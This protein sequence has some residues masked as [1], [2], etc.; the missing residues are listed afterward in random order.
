MCFRY[1]EAIG[2]LHS[3]KLHFPPPPTVLVVSSVAAA[4]DKRNQ[5]PYITTIISS[6][7]RFY[8]PPSLMWGLCMKKCLPGRFVV[9]TAVAFLDMRPCNL[10]QCYRRQAHL[11]CR[12]GARSRNKDRYGYLKIHKQESELQ[13]KSEHRHKCY[14]QAQ[15]SKVK[16]QVVPL[17]N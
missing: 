9:C 14:T 17:L 11:H 1:T 4:T 13:G 16:C 3:F 8:L 15:N 5:I 7:V 6:E 12:I 10:V 2:F